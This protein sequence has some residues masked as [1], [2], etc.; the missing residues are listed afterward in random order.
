MARTKISPEQ[1]ELD[2]QLMQRIAAKDGDALAEFSNRFYPLIY[3]TA[4]KV[5][6]HAEDTEDV[7]A[8]VLNTVWKKADSYHPQKGSLVTWICTT[9]RNRAIDRI[10]SVQRRAA[11]YG[12]FEERVKG[13]KKELRTSGREE[14][15]RSDARRVLNQAVVE[16]TPEQR[17]VIELAYFEGL[18]QRQIAEKTDCPLGTVKARIR[19]GVERL[20]GMMDNEFKGEGE[21]L[22]NS[23]SKS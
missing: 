7:S 20:R 4:Y 9:A 13:D 1:R 5:L 2:F 19:R 21:L 10:R 11:L 18:T 16:L 22:L 12:R 8:E 14:L 6:R 17:E 15:Y 3:S 23:V